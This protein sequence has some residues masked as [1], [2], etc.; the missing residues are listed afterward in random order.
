MTIAHQFDY[1]RPETLDEALAILSEHGEG[2]RILAGGTDLVPWMRDDAAH[3]QVVVDVKR[4][5]ELNNIEIRNGTLHIGA[6]VTFSA[7]TRSEAVLVHA[8]VLVE[9]ARTVG[10]IGIRNR[11]TLVGNICSA[12]PS[13]DGGPPLLVYQAVVQVVGPRGSRVVPIGEWFAGP[14]RTVL[15]PGEIVTDVSLPLPGRQ[16]GCYVKLSRYRGEDLAQVAVAVLALPNRRYRIAFGAVGPTPVR[17]PFIEALLDGKELGHDLLTAAAELVDVTIAPIGDVR[18]S[19]RYRA[20][21]ARVM[22]RRG[23]ETAVA[24]LA[25]E[26]PPLGTEV[27]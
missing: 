21:K 13:L 15:E 2:A 26:G 20:H 3:P 24:R 25:G 12:V 5:P 16:G 17:A 1:V 19:A 22:L 9:A 8:P 23:L 14:H 10:S 4:V 18:A 27:L 7:L 11:A 6:L